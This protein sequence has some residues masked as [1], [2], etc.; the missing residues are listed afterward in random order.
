MKPW[1]FAVLCGL[2]LPAWGYEKV[3]DE[4]A[5]NIVPG[6]VE[7]AVIAPDG[8]QDMRDLPL[9]LNLHGGGGSR[10]RLLQQAELWQRL[11]L[12]EAIPP[13]VV[14]MPSVTARGVYMNFKDAANA[15][16]TLSCMSVLRTC[17]KPCP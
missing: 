6:P 2:C 13:A 12:S 4:V 8:Y 7:Y 9:V 5:S 14:V 1:M 10:E 11:W 17:R 15:G 16:K 3:L